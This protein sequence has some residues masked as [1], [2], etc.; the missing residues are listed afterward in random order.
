MSKGYVMVHSDGTAEANTFSKTEQAAKINALAAVFGHMVFKNDTPIAVDAAF[1]KMAVDG[2]RVIPAEITF[3]QNEEKKMPFDEAPE[4]EPTG[5][6]DHSHDPKLMDRIAITVLTGLQMNCEVNG[7]C[8][9]CAGIHLMRNMFATLHE[10][11]PLGAA[12]VMQ[13]ITKDMMDSL[14]K[15]EG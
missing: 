5:G 2:Q 12:L 3:T 10:E 8:I 6:D 14:T 11:D 1:K 9:K 7:A 15:D 4:E 13:T